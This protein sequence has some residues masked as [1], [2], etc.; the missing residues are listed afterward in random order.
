MDDIDSKRKQKGMTLHLCPLCRNEF[1]CLDP[2]CIGLR[3]EWCDNCR[4]RVTS[5]LTK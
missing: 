2:D 5:Y 3:Y 1:D 4:M